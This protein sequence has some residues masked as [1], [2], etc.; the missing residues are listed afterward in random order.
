VSRAVSKQIGERLEEIV[1]DAADELQAATV[2]DSFDGADEDYW[3]DAEPEVALFAS[4]QVPMLGI[5]VIEPGQPV[6]IKAASATISSGTRSCA[7]RF[8]L[9][10]GQHER[11]VAENGV[12]LFAIYTEE[13]DGDPELLGLLAVPAVI[14][15]EELRSTWYCVDW[16]SDYYQ[17]S[18][19]RLPF[20]DLG[21]DRRVE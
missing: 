16:R 17:L 4:E 7:G 1:V 13:D 10:R 9:T 5:C 11:L 2:P 6:E 15:E 18:A 14:V 3:Y 19:S 20:D 12:Y 21:G 8:Y